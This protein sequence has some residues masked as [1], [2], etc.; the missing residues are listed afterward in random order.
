MS[1]IFAEQR[2]IGIEDL[3]M[4]S[5]SVNTTFLDF[6]TTAPQGPEVFVANL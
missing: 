6:I 3:T 5:N 1:L 2:A 4:R